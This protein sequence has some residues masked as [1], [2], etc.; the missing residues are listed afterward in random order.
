MFRLISQIIIDNSERLNE[1]AFIFN[2]VILLYST[3]PFFINFTASYINNSNEFLNRRLSFNCIKLIEVFSS[4][5]LLFPSYNPYKAVPVFT[6]IE[7]CLL[8]LFRLQIIEKSML[9]LILSVILSALATFSIIHNW[10]I[11][12]GLKINRNQCYHVYS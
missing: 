5:S 6:M 2:N 11:M 1:T 12:I 3:F 10:M 9:I 8:P 7:T 4:S